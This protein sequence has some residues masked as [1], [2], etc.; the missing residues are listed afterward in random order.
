MGSFKENSHNDRKSPFLNESDKNDGYID[1][2]LDEG[3]NTFLK[4]D[5]NLKL[6]NRGEKFQIESVRGESEGES[7][8]ETEN[9]KFKKRN[10]IVAFKANDIKENKTTSINSEKYLN[11]RFTTV[12]SS[13]E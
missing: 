11:R 8:V 13:N 12:N 1:S 2:P 6:E 3:F 7:D 9:V 10:T 5:F 4:S